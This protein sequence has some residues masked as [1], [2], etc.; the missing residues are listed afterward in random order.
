[1]LNLLL[2]YVSRLQQIVQNRTWEGTGKWQL[3]K[4]GPNGRLSS[5]FIEGMSEAEIN[6]MISDAF[7]VATLDRLQ[8][9]GVITYQGKKITLRGYTES[10]NISSAFIKKIE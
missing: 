7:S 10:G 6:Q 9:E 2:T 4:A 8:W 3:K 5:C 1:M